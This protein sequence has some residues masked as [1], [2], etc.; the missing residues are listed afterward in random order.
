MKY[1]R[2]CGSRALQRKEI[3]PWIEVELSHTKVFG[4]IVVV[5]CM[6]SFIGIAD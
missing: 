4:D 2:I 3:K 5:N 1:V 6:V